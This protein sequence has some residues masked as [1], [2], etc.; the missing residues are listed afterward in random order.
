MELIVGLIII[1][2]IVFL[3]RAF[4]AWMLR[5]DEVIDVQKEI[6]KELKKHSEN[7]T[8]TISPPKKINNF[9]KNCGALIQPNE[10]ECP[11]CG[12]KSEK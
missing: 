7:L 12:L 11:K 4:G 6:L 1:I 10:T 3:I 5:I 8:E 9:C 2:V